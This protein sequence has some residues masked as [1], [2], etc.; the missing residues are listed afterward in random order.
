MVFDTLGYLW[1]CTKDGLNRYDGIG[2]KVFRHDDFNPH[3]ISNSAAAR[4]LL[5]RQG[6]LWLNTETHGID[7][8]HPRTETFEHIR[9]KDG[10]ASDN[11]SRLA[12]GP[13]DHLFVFYR[14]TTRID[15]LTRNPETGEVNISGISAAFPSLS[16]AHDWNKLQPGFEGQLSKGPL[17]SKD[18]SLWNQNISDSIILLKASSFTDGGP[19]LVFPK[20]KNGGT[21]INNSLLMSQDRADVYRYDST[22]ELSKFNWSE[23][24][25]EPWVKLP[26]GLTFG[27]FIFVD[28]LG[29]IWLRTGASELHRI[30]VHSNS[31]TKIVTDI[32]MDFTSIVSCDRN[33]NIWLTKPGASLGKLSV[34]NDLFRRYSFDQVNHSRV[35]LPRVERPGKKADY[36]KVTIKNWV[37][38]QNESFQKTCKK[39]TENYSRNVTID[40]RGWFILESKY[41]EP[42]EDVNLYAFDPQTDAYDKIFEQASHRESPGSTRIY[43]AMFFGL[44]DDLFYFRIQ[45]DLKTILVKTNVK[46]GQVEEYPL[47]IILNQWINR[48]LGDWEVDSDGTLWMA[49]TSGL[50]S[51]DTHTAVWKHFLPNPNYDDKPPSNHMLSMCHNP[52]DCQDNI[53]WIGTRGGLLR[54]DKGSEEFKLFTTQNGLPNDVVYGVQSDATE[55]IW[56]ST[57]FGLCQFNVNTEEKW[58]FISSDGINGN[59]FNSY[60]YSKA[61]DGTMCFGGIDGATV[62]HPDD[63]KGGKAS[64]ISIN[65]LRIN[66]KPIIYGEPEGE[67]PAGFTLSEPIEFCSELTFDHDVGMISLHFATLDLTVPQRNRYRYKLEGMQ[68]EWV[69]AGY[70]SEAI[71]SGLR[72]GKYTFA[73]IGCNSRNSWSA[74]T[75]IDITILPPWY[76][77]WWFRSIIALILGAMLY[78]FYRYRVA[79][80]LRVEKMRNRI[81][82]DLHDEV[83][84]TLSS[85]SLYGAAMLRSSHVLPTNMK[86]ILD[87]IVESTSEMIEGMNDLVWTIKADNDSFEKVVS[88]MRAFAVKMTEARGITLQ[89]RA[90]PKAEALDLNMEKRKN[91]YLIFKEAVN[92]AAKYS[93]TEILTVQVRFEN[94]TLIIHVKDEGDGFNP[95]DSKNHVN[96]LGGNGLHGMQARAKEINADFNLKSSPGDGCIVTLRV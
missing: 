71:F 28:D 30:D 68:T 70:K 50:F 80:L 32:P 48:F 64:A 53:F 25:F 33:G 78:G 54:F 41:I 16:P 72:P 96:P 19:P 77:T 84:S 9:V 45:A 38:T 81:A 11:I 37:T 29:R 7:I 87:K 73:V 43:G 2:F 92:N 4:I 61:N 12:Q 55:H 62:F 40:D 46:N 51:F 49:T 76:A 3:S 58:H 10:L 35:F 22:T 18:G 86:D 56:L 79:E 59:E 91:I 60:Q 90:D 75:T 44:N 27:D 21:T 88:R 24:R 74:P 65:E 13:G 15:V 36:D 1:L 42:G 89:F 85:I 67:N 6:I 93:N 63:F 5:D 23:E 57:N 17:F 8:Y 95:L 34:R 39:R 26:H 94:G 83:G 20:G 47:P 14:D 52:G 69:E 66:N 82:Q 31:I